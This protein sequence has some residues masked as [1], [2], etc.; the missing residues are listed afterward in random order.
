MIIILLVREP[1]DDGD[2]NDGDDEEEE[3]AHGDGAQK[4][5]HHAVRRIDLIQ[6]FK[7]MENYEEGAF[8]NCVSISS[9][10]PSE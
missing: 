7:D 9:T 3:D 5:R 1:N 10:Y 2:D 4:T 8:F 6:I